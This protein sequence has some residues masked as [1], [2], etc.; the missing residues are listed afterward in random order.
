MSEAD[1]GALLER[2]RGGDERAGR[3]LFE[4]HFAS[5]FRFFRNKC[6]D[7]A[8]DLVHETFLA[9]LKSSEPFKGRSSFRTYLFRAA[10]SKLYDHWRKRAKG[11]VLDE[12]MSSIM[13]L[14]ASPST[15]LAAKREERLL[16][17]ALRR[18]P[19]ELQVALSLFYFED[20]T[21][22]EIAEVLDIPEGTAR[23]RLSRARQL[24]E[25]EMGKIATS[26][27]LLT[28]TVSDLEGWARRVRDLLAG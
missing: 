12:S 1:D 17:E 18:L 27:E 8:E 20:M 24:V 16:L 5:L 22:P 3:E 15:A 25:E 14:G 13:D 4:R 7:A 23:S 19:L 28:S 10:R 9:V 11:G 26:G 6:D 21:G 2:W